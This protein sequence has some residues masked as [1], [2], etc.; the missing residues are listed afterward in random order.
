MNRINKANKPVRTDPE[1]WEKCKHEAIEKMGTFSARAMQHAVVLYKKY[2]GGYV[3]QKSADN[4]LV[5]WN[6]KQKS[7]FKE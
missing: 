3:G 5:K 7:D 1:L 6:K 4:A 2:G